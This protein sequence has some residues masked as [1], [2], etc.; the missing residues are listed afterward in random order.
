MLCNFCAPYKSQSLKTF[1]NLSVQ[2]EF[3]QQCRMSFEHSWHLKLPYFLLPFLW[4]KQVLLKL[5]V[6][7]FH[8]LI[9]MHFTRR[10]GRFAKVVVLQHSIYLNAKQMR[11]DLSSFLHSNLGKTVAAVA[12][13]D[14]FLAEFRVSCRKR[15]FHM[16][17]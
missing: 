14:G 8:F 1:V 5:P 4:A 9:Q 7:F 2:W 3:K 11:K 15:C 13:T 6:Y 17:S 16:P 10:L 12:A